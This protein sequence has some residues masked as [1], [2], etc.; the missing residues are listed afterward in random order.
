[1]VTDM[2]ANGELDRDEVIANQPIVRL[3]RA[4]EMAATVLWLCSFGAS[5][6][7][8]VAP[9]PSMSTTP[10]AERSRRREDRQRAATRLPC[11]FAPGRVPVP[12]TRRARRDDVCFAWASGTQHEL[13]QMI[14]LDNGRE[15]ASSSPSGCFACGKPQRALAE[16]DRACKRRAGNER[17][18]RPRPPLRAQIVGASPPRAIEVRRGTQLGSARGRWLGRRAATGLATAALAVAWIESR[19]CPCALGR[20]AQHADRSFEELGLA[21]YEPGG[22]LK[23]APGS[24]ERFCLPAQHRPALL[25]Q[26]KDHID[27][28]EEVTRQLRLESAFALDHLL[29]K[30]QLA[31][32]RLE[33]L[34]RKLCTAADR[35]RRGDHRIHQL[36]PLT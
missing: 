16:F 25:E 29:H 15:S 27:R 36:P 1:M 6:V 9:S 8:G 32:H 17:R 30:L 3:G 23:R 4:D 35:R 21:L 26:V 19:N 11:N 13:G 10:R 7:L 12:L 28:R 5:F 22:L 14:Q 34:T 33:Q 31:L 24:L 2:I 18:R 20:F